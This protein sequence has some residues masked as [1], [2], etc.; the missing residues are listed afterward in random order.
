MARWKNA[1]LNRD[2]QYRLKRRAVILEAGRAFN[3]DGF[4][5]TS[6]DEIAKK[7]AV[8]KAA[9][10]YYVKSKHEILF[11][12]HQ[13]AHDLA[14]E[15]IA[16]ARRSGRTGMDKLSHFLARYIENLTGEFGSCVV[17]A[18]VNALQPEDRRRIVVRRDQFDRAL[19]GMIA[20]GIKDGS[21]RDCDPKLLGF[22]IMGAV[23]WIPKW[24]S[25]EGPMTG[26]AIAERFVD[27]IVAA[28][29]PQA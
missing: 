17:L 25:P 14:D 26:R 27:Y 20:D 11:E 4:H 15:A 23:N 6:L 18:D 10:Y 3:E 8:T 13:L 9:L 29:R 7:L 28:I 21:I 24:F 2:E 16:D 1:A 12:C 5:A 19:R 22:L